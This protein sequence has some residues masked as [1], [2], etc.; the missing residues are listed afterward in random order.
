MRDEISTWSEGYSLPREMYNSPD[1]FVRDLEWLMQNQ[2]LLTGHISQIPEAGDF[3]LFEIGA[4]N[5]I[6]TRNREGEIRAFHNVCRHRGSRI[7]LEKQGKK[8]LFICPYHAWSYDLNGNLRAATSM[9]EDF[10][11]SQ[12]GLIPVH[13]GVFEGLIFVNFAEGDALNFEGFTERFIPLVKGQG[14]GSAKIATRK[15][16]PTKAN[17]KLVVDNFFECYHCRAAHQTYCQV[18]DDMKMIAFGAGAGSGRGPEVEQYLERLKLWET[19]A[20]EKGYPTGMFADDAHSRHF[21][22]GNRLPIADGALTESLDGQPLA[23]LM[24]EFG[25]FDGGQTGCVFTPLATLLVNNDHAVIFFFVPESP[26]STRME[27][28]WLVAPDAEE[29]KDYDCAALTKVWDTTLLED[30]TITENN[31]LGVDSR[32]YRP[33]RLSDMEAR[34]SEFGRWYMGHC[35][36]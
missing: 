14:V 7:C 35:K 20:A 33:G 19:G 28:I 1:V 31:Q 6:I 30:K 8:R 12:N 34:I 16:Y 10:D 18:H 23:P 3:Y 17:W 21:Q 11:R 36:T 2:W 25:S 22:S 5:I 9:P 24:G 15:S 4:E 29:G 27:T 13:V 26:N 32:V